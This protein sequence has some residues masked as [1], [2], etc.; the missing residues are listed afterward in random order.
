MIRSKALNGLHTPVFNWLK[1]METS[2]MPLTDSLPTAYREKINDLHHHPRIIRC[3]L[4]MQLFCQT[5]G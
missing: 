5:S 3:I 1:I 4:K 2:L